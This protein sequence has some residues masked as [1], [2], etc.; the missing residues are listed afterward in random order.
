LCVTCSATSRW[1]CVRTCAWVHMVVWRVVGSVTVAGPL[2]GRTADLCVWWFGRARRGLDVPVV[3]SFLGPPSRIG[4]DRWRKWWRQWCGDVTILAGLVT[5]TDGVCVCVCVSRCLWSCVCAAV[6]AY[7]CVSACECVDARVL[8]VCVCVCVLLCVCLCV[9]VCVCYVVVACYVDLGALSDMH[10]C[11]HV[12][13]RSGLRVA[14]LVFF[15]HSGPLSM[16]TPC[17][18]LS[19]CGVALRAVRICVCCERWS[20][21]CVCVAVGVYWCLVL[22]LS[23]G[24]AWLGCQFVLF[25]S[26]HAHV[27]CP[28]HE[29]VSVFHD[30]TYILCMTRYALHIQA[31]AEH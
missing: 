1:F 5:W 12:D 27:F 19:A 11:A 13:C 22:R 28:P 16:L 7:V 29:H 9:S 15:P 6:C 18:M 25:A 26:V 2:A 20:H 17:H 8:C 30:C 3:E 31:N 4:R 10:T 14:R 23:V 21:V 24:C